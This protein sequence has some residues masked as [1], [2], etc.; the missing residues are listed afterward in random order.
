[1]SK[2]KLAEAARQYLIATAHLGA[3]PGT[4]E[5]LERAI[6]EAEAKPA[7]PVAW[8]QTILDRGVTT[9]RL[10]LASEFPDMDKKDWAAFVKVDP[11]YAAPAAPAPVP[12]TDEQKGDRWAELLPHA[13]KFT[14]ADWFEAG[15]DFAERF[16]G[17]GKGGEA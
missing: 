14:S 12:L 3:C 1:M 7:E 10:F 15:A 8:M 17:I 4:R 9:K 16:H 6:A 11:L 5:V 2:D 13:D